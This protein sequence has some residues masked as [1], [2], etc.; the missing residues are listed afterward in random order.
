M[1]AD[2]AKLIAELLPCPFCGYVGIDK[3]GP[4]TFACDACGSSSPCW[5][6]RAALSA[7]SE[8]VACPDSFVDYMK[9]NYSG[10][11]VFSNPAWH[12]KHI[13]FAVHKLAAHPVASAQVPTLIGRWRTANGYLFCGTLRIAVAD[14]DTT[15]T[16]EHRDT[17]L[18][19]I[20]QAMNAAIGASA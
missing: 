2:N 4:R 10:E 17:I 14:F 15:P 5:N 3:I 7:Q 1:S 6:R 13:W 20:C 18:E 11:V 16:V 8:P 12:A 9:R 19:E